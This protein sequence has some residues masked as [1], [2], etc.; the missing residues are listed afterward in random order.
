MHTSIHLCGPHDNNT[1][2]H[3]CGGNEMSAE[4]DN[5]HQNQMINKHS[6]YIQFQF[7]S[8]LLF[9]IVQWPRQNIC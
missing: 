5:K 7:N 1:Q 4:T 2:I 9:C 3:M 8:V 6:E